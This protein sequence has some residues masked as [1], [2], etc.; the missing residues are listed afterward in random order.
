MCEILNSLSILDEFINFIAGST[1]SIFTLFLTHL[2]SK[3][4]LK[5]ALV[6]DATSQKEKD[7]NNQ[8]LLNATTKSIQA[9]SKYASRTFIVS[10]VGM[11]AMIINTFKGNDP[12][13][14]LQIINISVNFIAVIGFAYVLK[15][16]LKFY[17]DY[18][19]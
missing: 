16:L 11:I 6:T 14:T 13:T 17:C 8:L 2:A 7:F 1:L 19:N 9:T 5:K 3:S 10:A 15:L 18:K 4:E 12:S